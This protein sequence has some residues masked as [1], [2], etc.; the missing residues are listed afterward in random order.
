M[1][2]S[3]NI[4]MAVILTALAVCVVV[5][6]L[7]RPKAEETIIVDLKEQMREESPDW[8]KPGR[9]WETFRPT[10][11][12][13]PD[14]KNDVK[15]I[16]LHHTAYEG[17]AERVVDDLCNPNNPVSCHVVIDKDGT[18]YVLAPPEAV[19][20]HAGFSQ[21][22]GRF[23]VNQFMIGIEFQGNT[24]VEPLTREQIES[25]LEYMGP[26]IKEHEISRHNIVTHE[27][28][29]EAYRKA[30]PKNKKAWP[31]VDIT[32]VEYLRVMNALDTASLLR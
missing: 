27:M 5:L 22:N 2:I 11:N 4:W 32:P 7:S 15:G 16:V 17:D 18:R 25:A 23:R 1:R 12:I 26:I 24:V 30:I 21:W 19:T 6:L 13:Y 31:K 3:C 8:H 20:W 10:P 14:E 28:I 9:Y 29:R